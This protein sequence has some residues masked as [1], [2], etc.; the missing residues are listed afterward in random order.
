VTAGLPCRVETFGL[1]PKADWS[2]RPLG[3]R[4]GRHDFAVLRHGSPWAEVRL[5]VPGT[6]NVLN[7]LAAAAL[8]SH[9]GVR[10]DQVARTLGA[11]RGIARRLEVV[12]SW[13]GVVVVD[14]YA[15]HPTEVSAAL[16][17][18]R[19]MYPGRRVWAVFQPHQAS[20]TGRL[21]DE[22]AASLQN[23]EKVVVSEVFRARE[24]A[25]TSGEVTAGDL[26]RRVRDLGTDVADVHADDQI[27]PL[28]ERHLRP[29]DVLVIMGAGDIG[30]LRDA[31]RHRLREDR[32]AG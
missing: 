22:L 25:P 6:H 2:A 8:A 11:F 16:R 26:A 10:P 23:A 18:V 3:S 9:H 20:R 5:R 17:T 31:L 13:R 27:V 4:R 19:R 14:D 24:P 12:G 32:A 1:D 15:H 21:L 29:G 30:K 28:L 7:A